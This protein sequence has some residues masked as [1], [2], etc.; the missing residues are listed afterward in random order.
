MQ[1]MILF[2]STGTDLNVSETF[3]VQGGTKFQ[4]SLPADATLAGTR[5]GTATKNTQAGLYDVTVAGQPGQEARFD[6]NWTIPFVVPEELSGK[7]LH[8][9]PVRMVFP[10]GIKAAGS[11]LEAN[12]TEP[13]T[14]A[15]IYTLKG[16]TYK[17][18][19]DGA[20]TLRSQAPQQ[21]QPEEEQGPR[22]EQILPRIYDKK[23]LVLGLT[24]GIL[25]IGF[26]LNYRASVKG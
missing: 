23:Y 18:T 17:I 26:I 3:M 11:M 15:S 6:I 19:I 10:K 2:E 16:K 14:Q 24:I 20:G 7:V 12:G 1:Q 25:I 4:V 21:Q 9:A 13:T 8:T 5:G 22:I